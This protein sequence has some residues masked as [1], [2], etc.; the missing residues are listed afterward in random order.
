MT[1]FERQTCANR[2]REDVKRANEIIAK[3]VVQEE[4]FQTLKKSGAT[5][6]VFGKHPREVA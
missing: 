6:L 2:E 1:E 3:V 4:D 5:K